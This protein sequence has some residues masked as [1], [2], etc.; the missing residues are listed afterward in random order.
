MALPSRRGREWVNMSMA[1]KPASAERRWCHKTCHPEH[2]ETGCF[3]RP[4]QG[5]VEDIA[6]HDLNQDRDHHQG[7]GKDADAPANSQQQRIDEV[8][9][10]KNRQQNA[11]SGSSLDQP[12][13]MCANMRTVKLIMLKVVKR[14]S[15]FS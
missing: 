6:E 5:I 11:H 8:E 14:S 12:A 4:G 15:A 10:C 3:V 7:N 13:F 9:R 1:T 2:A